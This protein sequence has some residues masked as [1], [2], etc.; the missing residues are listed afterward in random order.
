MPQVPV[1]LDVE[2]G[3]PDLAVDELHQEQTPVVA[4]AGEVGVHQL[5]PLPPGALRRLGE[6]VAR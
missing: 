3:G 2:I 6:A 4:L 1:S 5:G